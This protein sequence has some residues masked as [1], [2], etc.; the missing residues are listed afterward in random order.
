MFGEQF[1]DL[2]WLWGMAVFGVALLLEQLNGAIGDRFA[3]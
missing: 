3:A 2:L 1:T